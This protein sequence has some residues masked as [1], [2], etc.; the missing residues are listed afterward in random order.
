MNRAEEAFRRL[1]KHNLRCSQCRTAGVYHSV[2]P[3][4]IGKMLQNQWESIEK[5]AAHAE[6]RNEN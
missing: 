5:A 3:C 4:P 2:E 6:R 1:S